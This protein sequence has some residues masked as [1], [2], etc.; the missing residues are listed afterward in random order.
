VGGPALVSIFSDACFNLMLKSRVLVLPFWD[1]VEVMNDAWFDNNRC[2]PMHSD[3]LLPNANCTKFP[4]ISFWTLQ[5]LR[6]L[7]KFA[8]HFILVLF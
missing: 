5:F 3:E 8:H 1:G 2:K 4:G 7:S 6:D